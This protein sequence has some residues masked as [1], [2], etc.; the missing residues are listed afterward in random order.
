MGGGLGCEYMHLCIST[1]IY[2]NIHYKKW[3]CTH[4]TLGKA[5][6]GLGIS[7]KDGERLFTVPIVTRMC[8][9]VLNWNRVRQIGQKFGHSLQW[10]CW[11]ITLISLSVPK[12]SPLLA[13]MK[14]INSLQPITAPKC[15][16][17]LFQGHQ[18]VGT[19]A[20]PSFWRTCL[21]LTG[22]S[23]QS[24]SCAPKSQK[25]TPWC[26]L[27]LHKQFPSYWLKKC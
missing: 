5:K 16:M 27:E 12:H 21:F 20:L 19:T 8:A 13:T 17:L 23:C 10:G 6:I 14:K 3:K 4:S 11:D 18:P 25:K 7:L 15:K 26:P 1:Y 9:T 24:L 22:L 2:A